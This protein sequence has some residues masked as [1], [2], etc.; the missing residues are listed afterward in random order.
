MP[1]IPNEN[2][3]PKVFVC[4]K[5]AIDVEP[6]PPSQR[7]NRNAQQGYLNRLKDT[8]DTLR[9]IVEEARSNRTS[10][11]SLEYACVY[12]KTSQE[13]L[14]KV[15]ASCP[16]TV[17]KEIDTMLVRMLKGTNMSPLLNNLKISPTTHL[18]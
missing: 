13:L 5:Y 7:N 15:I 10:D 6:I 3:I 11:N 9:E 18:H 14:E 12:T 4:N 2:V 17:T 16:K 8:L 1:V